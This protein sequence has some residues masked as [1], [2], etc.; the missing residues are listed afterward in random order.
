MLKKKIVIVVIAAVV[1][2]VAAI[3]Y[4]QYSGKPV[5]GSDCAVSDCVQSQTPQVDA[6]GHEVQAGSD[7]H[8]QEVVVKLKETAILEF[9]IQTAA[10][11][12]GTIGM[13]T[14]LPAEI[15]LNADT[16]A[17]V[18]PRIA[19][20]VRTVS[21]NLGDKVKAGQV[22]AV[23][24]S[25]EL[26]D[27]KAGYLGAREKLT[28]AEATHEREKKLWEKKITA[29]QEYLDAKRQL[30]DAR[31]EM[32]SAAQKLHALGFSQA[33]LEVLPNQPDESFIVYEIAA[34][35]AGTI[36]EKHITLGESL[37]EDSEPFVIADL[38]NVWARVNVGQ[39]DLPTV[40]C[41][42]KAVIKTEHNQ[43]EGVV[44]YVSSV[45]EENTRTALARIVLPNEDGKWRPGA[46]ATA[47]IYTASVEC[48]I[49]V[50]SE[51]II[52]MEG[53]S[54]VFIAEAEGFVPKEVQ[55]GKANDQLTE[56]VSGLE[57]GQKY[58][59]KG[60]FTLKS[61]MTKSNQDPCGGH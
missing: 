17:H 37:K 59:I 2:S 40:Q 55:L 49:V 1:L 6:H 41:G 30:A 22:L 50:A 23:L 20:V 46:F 43:G 39:K 35:I 53:E 42:Q 25:R 54:F 44:S 10:V 51:A 28:L 60:A 4:L 61:E 12:G 32:R 16:V 13:H 58:V 26:S 14:T 52:T 8:G 7:G 38:S 24:H 56:I 3:V 15:V 18:V 5:Y 31:I 19:G 9:G 36:I 21:K 57:V 34:P 45:L 33:D 27:Y 47:S 48:K 11:Q 29:E